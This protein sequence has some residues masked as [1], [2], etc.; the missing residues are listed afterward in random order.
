MGQLWQFSA[1]A[2]KEHLPLV[3]TVSYYCS[4][5]N[6][7]L[8]WPC[9]PRSVTHPERRE[10]GRKRVWAGATRPLAF[11]KELSTLNSL[12][13]GFHISGQT[14]PIPRGIEPGYSS[15]DTL[16]QGS[17]ALPGA[18]SQPPQQ[19][20]HTYPHQLTLKMHSKCH[21]HPTRSHFP[22]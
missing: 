9:Q 16:P 19:L 11:N 13:W 20:R 22:P 15:K 10:R 5:W 12:E 18:C 4:L 2:E 14:P 6:S 21:H 3:E 8:Q 7:P 1:C 17:Q